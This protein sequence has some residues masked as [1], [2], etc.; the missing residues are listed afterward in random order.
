MP[1]AGGGGPPSFPEEG[2]P[3]SGGFGR[4]SGP[5]LKDNLS[6]NGTDLAFETSLLYLNVT[7]KYVGINT[8]GPSSDLTIGTVKNNGGTTSSSIRSTN[9]I[10]TTTSTIG[11]FTISGSTIQHL[12]SSITI[13]PNQASNPTIVTPGLSTS[14]LYLYGNTVSNTVTNASTNITP[15]GNN[16]AMLSIVASVNVSA[17][18]N[19]TLPVVQA[20][21]TYGTVYFTTGSGIG[22]EAF[23]VTQG[24][25]Y[26]TGLATVTYNSVT[27]NVNI[28][29]VVTTGGNINFTNG[30]GN[31]AVNV[32]ADLHA[33]GNITWDG[34]ITLGNAST[35]DITFA[36]KINTDILPQVL[37]TVITPVS[38][39]MLTEALE[40]FITEDSQ[41]LFTDPP[42]P[43]NVITPLYDLGSSSL[44]WNNIWANTLSTTTSTVDAITVTTAT[45]GNFTF[46]GNTIN[47][48]SNDITFN[49]TGTGQVNLNGRRYT[50]GNDIVQNT[51]GGAFTLNSTDFGYLKF[52]GNNGV[53][54]PVGDTSTRPSAPAVG[55]LR[56]NSDIAYG[57]LWNGTSWIPVGGAAITLS[58]EQVTDVNY[59]WDLILG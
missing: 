44:K 57:E 3:A 12:T 29:S 48:Q 39:Q 58:S 13:V 16:G 17:I 20:G 52:G 27:Y 35:D 32:N 53:A 55:T 23:I 36:A 5:L 33:T 45:L 30:A 49:P 6:R 38:Q 15:N 24:K 51:A 37:T 18:Y 9:V 22:D 8:Q 11:N 50:V 40:L 1:A 59:A 10:A 25:G 14:N 7:G 2:L 34:N 26:I 41:S 19:I 43:Y 4:I 28:A 56:Y 46:T 54:F 42:G 31:V 47:N 21:A